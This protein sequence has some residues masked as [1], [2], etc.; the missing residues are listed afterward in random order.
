MQTTE[1]KTQAEARLGREL[2]AF[3]A[4]LKNHPQSTSWPEVTYEIKILGD[5]GGNVK[6]FRQII[7]SSLPSITSFDFIFLV[8]FSCS[9]CASRTQK[10]ELD[11]SVLNCCQ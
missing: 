6:C 10:I 9:D 11:S 1:A 2:G 4:I 8:V 3:Q 7:P 5:I